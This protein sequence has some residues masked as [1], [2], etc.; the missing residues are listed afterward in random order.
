MPGSNRS[1][2]VGNE[3]LKF[4][5]DKYEAFN[6]SPL[7]SAELGVT[8]ATTQ[9]AVE[10]PAGAYVYKVQL[11]CTGAIVS[12]DID[13][14]DGDSTD[15]FIDGVTTMSANDILEAPNVASGAACDEVAGHYYG[16]QDTIDVKT[17]A[18]ATSGS[19]KLMVWYTILD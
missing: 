3:R 1:Y 15:R 4:D 10:V 11:Y 17:N 16:S 2:P 7:V 5:A 14:G 13:V 12:A 8:T 9:N 18:T 19:V 6:K